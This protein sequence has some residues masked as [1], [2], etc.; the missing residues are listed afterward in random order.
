[1]NSM[2]MKKP[3]L[4]ARLIVLAV[5][6]AL[7]GADQLI[8]WWMTQELAVQRSRVLIPGVLGL[9]Y[10]ENTGISF[11]LF[12]DSQIAMR[13][14]SIVTALVMLAGLIALMI[15][16]IG[17][18]VPLSGAALILSGGIGNLID[19]LAHG[20]VVDY[21]ELLFMRFAI[22]NFADIC[23]TCGVLVVAAWVIWGE[24]RRPKQV[25]AK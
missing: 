17:G 12:G 10:A 5:T 4:W 1:M 3:K 11:S 7:L 18:A 21:I 23:I 24:I 8:K 14:I 25:N 16:K 13:A 19:R 20:Y 15:G 6:A 2:N 22:F 9:H